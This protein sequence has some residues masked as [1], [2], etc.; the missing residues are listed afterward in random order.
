VNEFNIFLS[1]DFLI[2]VRSFDSDTI[3]RLLQKYKEPLPADE[4]QSTA[5]L[6][7]SI[8]DSM[9]DKV[10]RTLDSFTRDLRILEKEIF[11]ASGEDLIRD[12]MIKK[13]N[14]I[15]LKHMLKPQIAALKILE[16]RVNSLFSRSIEVYFENLQDKIESIFSEIELLQENIDSMEDTLKSIFEMKTN[17]TIKYL[18]LFSAFMLPLTLITS[19]FGMN[20][21]SVPFTN[22]WVYGSFIVTTLLLIACI[23]W[24]VKR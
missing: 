7:Y 6:L 20:L 19:F 10:F 23:Y 16:L 8:I 24:L 21:E 9:L 22:I 15:V 5:F 14:V 18:T 1:P 3:N 11:H 12:I 4:S 13:R 17:N 2:T